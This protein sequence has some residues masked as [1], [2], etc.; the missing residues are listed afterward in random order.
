MAF[1]VAICKFISDGAYFFIV[2]LCQ[3]ST[4]NIITVIP[5]QIVSV[6]IKIVYSLQTIPCWTELTF[7]VQSVQGYLLWMVEPD[8]VVELVFV[9]KEIG[10]P[11]IR[12]INWSLPLLHKWRIKQLASRI[13]FTIGEDRNAY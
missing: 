3:I 8:A 4:P 7:S 2:I 13:F 11:F 6:Y 9:N 1:I 5:V 12:R 10:K